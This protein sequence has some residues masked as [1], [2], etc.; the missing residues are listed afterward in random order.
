[1]LK[2]SPIICP[3]CWDHAIKPLQE[4]DLVA[5]HRTQMQF[6]PSIATYYCSYWHVFAVFGCPE[7]TA[8]T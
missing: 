5:V 3:I 8:V 7:P 2:E 4:V 1:V 6:V